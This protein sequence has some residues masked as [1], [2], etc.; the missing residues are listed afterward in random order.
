MASH[1]T[2]AFSAQWV[3]TA[4]PT[5]AV[6]HWG[7]SF[8][9]SW[10]WDPPYWSYWGQNPSYGCVTCSINSAH[11]ALLV[12]KQKKSSVDTCELQAL[13]GVSGVSVPL[14]QTI[15]GALRFIAHFAA[16]A[17]SELGMEGRN[18]S[19]ALTQLTHSCPKLSFSPKPWC[20]N[21]VLLDDLK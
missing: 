19:P 15:R 6:A 1:T 20:R 17:C 4:N 12:D 3:H 14:T 16:Q 10:I 5:A 18:L 11:I 8:P 13:A 9:S 21:Q 2:Q 7:H